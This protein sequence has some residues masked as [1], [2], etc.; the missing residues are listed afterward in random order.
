MKKVIS[1]IL[2]VT[3]L[4]STQILDASSIG[5]DFLKGSSR[6]VYAG[7]LQPG[8]IIKEEFSSTDVSFALNGIQENS[9]TMEYLIKE[10]SS[11]V[12]KIETR[13]DFLRHA[14]KS[15]TEEQINGFAKFMES[16][17]KSDKELKQVLDFINSKKYLTDAQK[18]ILKE[19]SDCNIVCGELSQIL[20]S[21]TTAIVNLN[22]I[23]SEAGTVVELL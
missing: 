20:N 5:Y 22:S 23:I 16:Y 6:V 14:K 18:E 10:R 1:G 3:F 11:A 21:Q 8:N 2:V 12:A 15:L 19:K 9:R 13:M 7:V 4:S 17:E